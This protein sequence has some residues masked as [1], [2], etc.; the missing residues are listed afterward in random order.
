MS[1]SFKLSLVVHPMHIRNQWIS[2]WIPKSRVNM[3]YRSWSATSVGYFRFRFPRRLSDP[4]A[5]RIRC[6]HS[7]R[8]S[9]C[10]ALTCTHLPKTRTDD[11]FIQMR[12]MYKWTGR[13]QCLKN[14]VVVWLVS[15]F[16]FLGS[17]MLLIILAFWTRFV[18][19]ITA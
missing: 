10:S 1:N 19:F 9:A 4:H 2:R 14:I 3:N 15:F 7:A 11:H 17:T 6:S 12:I 16:T 8:V 5:E 18:N 13:S